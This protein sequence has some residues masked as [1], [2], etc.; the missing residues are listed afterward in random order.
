MPAIN[1]T[2]F[3]EKVE[4]G[5]KTQT[6]RATRKNP[7]KA[8]DRVV[9]MPRWHKPS[10]AKVLGVDSPD[11]A[12]KTTE[13]MVLIDTGG[14]HLPRTY[15]FSNEVFSFGEESRALILSLAAQWPEYFGVIAPPVAFWER[16]GAAAVKPLE[17][18]VE[19]LRTAFA[20]IKG[21]SKHR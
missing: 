20:M 3:I 6:I 5:R 11:W 9:Y 18:A 4:D 17:E 8:G 21:I 7:I 2:K 10:L 16:L 12:G 13:E 15:A 1:F 19:E 14:K